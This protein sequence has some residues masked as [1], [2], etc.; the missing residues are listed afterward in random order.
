MY[1]MAL[2]IINDTLESLD[3]NIKSEKIISGRILRSRTNYTNF[4]H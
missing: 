1:G 3:R 4:H 2:T